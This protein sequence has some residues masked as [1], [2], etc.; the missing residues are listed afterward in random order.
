[1][2]S[3]LLFTDGN[4]TH[5]YMTTDQ[6][7]TIIQC[8]DFLKDADQFQKQHQKSKLNKPK[9]RNSTKNTGKK[10]YIRY[11]TP[12]PRNIPTE[13]EQNGVGDFL[14]HTFG[15]GEDHKEKLLHEVA[16]L[17]KGSYH[18]IQ[19]EKKIAEAFISVLGGLLSTVTQDLKLTIM[20]PPNIRLNK[21]MTNYKVISVNAH[22]K[23][24]EFQDIQSEESLGI[25]VDI[26][27]PKL[28]F[29]PAQ[30]RPVVQTHLVYK[31]M[32]SNKKETIKTQVSVE[33][34]SSEPPQDLCVVLERERSRLGMAKA[35]KEATKKGDDGKLDAA[36]QVLKRQMEQINESR[37]RDDPY[38]SNLYQIL[39][40][41]LSNFQTPSAYSCY[42]GKNMYTV[43]SAA[44]A[45]ARY[46]GS[47]MGDG[48]GSNKT[49]K[50]LQA[51]YQTVT[52]NPMTNNK[53]HQ[54]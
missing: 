7:L 49:T 22:Q 35:I 17:G 13:T 44:S 18:F 43:F 46:T 16:E 9:Y 40:K 28:E 39:N 12:V 19:D 21:I 45:P 41:S 32:D 50:E 36:R 31:N 15:F 47:N 14:I 42:G 48:F 4:P 52:T 30:P 24:V 54:S 23:Y 11:E 34:V 10:L 8:P 20:T 25:L 3:I 27:L 2:A 5:G 1:V 53:T 51:A 38:V 26:D 29:V 6:I 33:R 37:M